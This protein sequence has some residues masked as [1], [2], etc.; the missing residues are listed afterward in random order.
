MGVHERA[1]PPHANFPLPL[2]S[3]VWYAT[4]SSWLADRQWR[5]NDAN[6]LEIESTSESTL[7]PK[8]SLHQ[9]F[10]TPNWPYIQRTKLY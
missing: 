8:P 10:M 6:A 3:S 7:L 9:C 1:R 4:A 2:T 5:C